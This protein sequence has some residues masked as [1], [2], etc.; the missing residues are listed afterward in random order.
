ML[1]M[2]FASSAI[3]ALKVLGGPGVPV[4]N[5]VFIYGGTSD[6]SELARGVYKHFIDPGTNG[7]VDSVSFATTLPEYG[8]VR[9][10]EV[11]AITG[12]IR[13]DGQ[14]QGN[15]VAVN[16]APGTCSS[17]PQIVATNT[18][19]EC[20]IVG[21][22]DD[23]SGNAGLPGIRAERVNTGALGAGGSSGS[24]GISFC[25]PGAGGVIACP[26][27]NPTSSS[28]AGCG[29]LG[30]GSEAGCTLTASGV[31]SLSADTVVFTSRGEG[32]GSP[33]LFVEG[34]ST[35]PGGVAFGGGVRCIGGALSKLYAGD[36]SGGTIVRPS[37]GEVSVHTRSA[38]LGT[39]ISPGE[40]RYYMTYY[41]YPNGAAQC[42]N[43]SVTFNT[44]QAVA[45]TW[46]S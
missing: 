3:D 27:G 14:T 21:W 41:R 4:T 18:C 35:I 39:P 15:G 11:D 24:I 6:N 32:M 25:L 22:Y 40:T 13:Y 45:I 17:Q 9:F 36:A 7:P 38:A 29:G 1:Q 19:A 43:R 5:A 34:T 31:A 37:V 26:C 42:G 8:Q 12:A 33:T 30:R 20:F 23:Q 44:S 28:G 16:T 2:R 10:S 46:G